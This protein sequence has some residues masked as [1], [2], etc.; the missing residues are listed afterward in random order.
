MSKERDNIERAI[1]FGQATALAI[2]LWLNRII[3]QRDVIKAA[4]IIYEALS[5]E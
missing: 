3:K 5:H 4:R 1:I 2:V